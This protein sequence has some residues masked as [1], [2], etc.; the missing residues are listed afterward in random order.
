[1]KMRI[2]N[3]DVAMR[4]M[5][6]LMQ[7]AFN[8]SMV[9]SLNTNLNNRRVF[10]I[11]K[12]GSTGTCT[13][14]PASI[15]NYMQ[16]TSQTIPVSQEKKQDNEYRKP[17]VDLFENK[18]HVFATVEIPG[19]NKE[20]IIVNS[21][22][23]GLVIRVDNK[24]ED[25]TNLIRRNIAYHKFVRTPKYADTE[26]LEATYKNGVLELKIPKKHIRR[27]PVK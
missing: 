5:N 12:N 25:A 17:H 14:Y 4:L 3:V 1:M 24:K 11:V 21:I 7:D 10:R 9:N 18:T 16:Q 26:K 22:T 19:V 13:R 23:D 6:A 27:I 8:R 15:P 20:D 2:T